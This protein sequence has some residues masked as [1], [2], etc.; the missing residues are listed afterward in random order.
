[1][2]HSQNKPLT[3][4]DGVSSQV[5]LDSTMSYASNQMISLQNQQN[6][7]LK[8]N[9]D[10]TNGRTTTIVVRSNATTSATTFPSVLYQMLNDAEIKG[11]EYIVSWLPDGRAFRVHQTE[12][13]LSDILPKYFAQTK[14]TS[15]QRQLN[16]YCFTRVT[17]GKDKGAYYHNYFL[18]GEPH[19]CNQITRMPFKGRK[20]KACSKTES[21]PNSCT[22]ESM[23]GFIT[24]DEP[25]CPEKYT[26]AKKASF[27]YICG[28]P[29]IGH[30][31]QPQRANG[32]QIRF[33]QN[34]NDQ[35]QYTQTRNSLVKPSITY[36]FSQEDDAFSFSTADW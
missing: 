25:I 17:A 12:R 34:A 30:I 1:V 10:N 14:F 36:T 19:L 29:N 26:N 15:L 6:K 16:M 9:P 18:R 8:S 20:T 27:E 24:W 11:N 5:Q 21:E 35:Y 31:S 4:I 3:H 32:Q 7:A 22:S 23:K 13:F 33:L 2:P 28:A